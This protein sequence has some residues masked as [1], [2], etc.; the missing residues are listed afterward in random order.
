MTMETQ[1]N[2][3]AKKLLRLPQ[4]FLGSVLIFV[5]LNLGPPRVVSLDS[6]SNF[7]SFTFFCALFFFGLYVIGLFPESKFKLRL[8]IA[9]RLSNARC[10]AGS[11]LIFYGVFLPKL[12]HV[13]RFFQN[14]DIFKYSVACLVF[15]FGLLMVGFHLKGSD[16]ET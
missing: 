6:L 5:G 3:Q 8:K 4:L 2:K 10:Y 1:Q 14:Q 9:S 11:F 12:H 7:L 13:N 16:S 15:L